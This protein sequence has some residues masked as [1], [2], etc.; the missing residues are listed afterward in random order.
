[1]SAAAFESSTWYHGGTAP[2]S[3]IDPSRRSPDGE[4][5]CLSASPNVAR[6]Y[7]NV[8]SRFALPRD[9]LVIRYALPDWMCNRAPAIDQLRDEGYHAVIIDAGSGSFDFPVETLFVITS[10]AV[11]YSGTLTAAELTRLDDGLPVTSEPA[12]GQPGWQEFVGSI[13][14]GDEPAALADLEP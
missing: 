1:M 10:D 12:P 4:L 5:L 13:Y 9:A 3:A 7:G 14:D 8:V 6:R 11:E 2:V